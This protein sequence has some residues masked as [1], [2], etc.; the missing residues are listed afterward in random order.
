MNLCCFLKFDT[1]KGKN[2]FFKKKGKKK[3]LFLARYDPSKCEDCEGISPEDKLR[4]GCV[5]GGVLL[6][7]HFCGIPGRVLL[8]IAAS[9]PLQ[10]SNAHRGWRDHICKLNGD[11]ER[12]SE[13]DDANNNFA[14]IIV[15]HSNS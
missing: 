2:F 1:K 13:V 12:A 4:G 14:G 7:R 5:R 10:H 15:P 6:W 3:K 9:L 11:V 8:V